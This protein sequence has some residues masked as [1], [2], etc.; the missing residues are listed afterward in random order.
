MSTNGNVNARYEDMKYLG[1][2]RKDRPTSE[3]PCTIP[4]CA[5]GC[6]PNPKRSYRGEHQT[7]PQ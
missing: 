1:V 7:P 4:N 2:K 5:A 6:V 3:R